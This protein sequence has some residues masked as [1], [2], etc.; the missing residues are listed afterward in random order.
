MNCTPPESYSSTI[1]R[2]PMRRSKSSKETRA[3]ERPACPLGGSPHLF[4]CR[5]G[6]RN[7]F[8]LV[9]RFT[10]PCCRNPHTLGQLTADYLR[11]SSPAWV[12]ED[13]LGQS[14]V[15]RQPCH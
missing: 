15:S 3:S 4:I 1:T 11:G 10:H 9:K 8:T 13:R 12:P 2:R 14:S 6:I 7:F 5:Q